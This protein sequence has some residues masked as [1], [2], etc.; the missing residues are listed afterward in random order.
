[1]KKWFV[2]LL[3]LV[4][5]AGCAAS[6]ETL[7]PTEETQKAQLANPWV[8]YE[9]LTEA[10]EAVGFPFS[11]DEQI[12]SF[13]A[14]SFRVMNGKLLEVGY[15]DADFRVTVRKQPGQ[16]QDLSGVYEPFSKETVYEAGGAEFTSRV[17]ADTEASLHLI[18][19]DGYS[20]SVYAP[21]GYPEDYKQGLLNAMLGQTP[22]WIRE[23][24]EAFCSS[25]WENG[26]TRESEIS[27]FFTSTWSSPEEIDLFAFLQ[28]CPLKE[29]LLDEHSEEAQA[30]IAAAGKNVFAVTPVWRY[31]KE[32][33]SSLLCKYTGITV[34]DLRSRENV[35]YLEEYDA[36]YNFT[37]DWG[38]G[39]F[40]CT[41]GEQSGN[42]ITLWGEG[43]G[44]AARTLTLREENG[45]YF[46][47]SFL[48]SGE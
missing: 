33:V 13:R 48:D 12:E 22:T 16:W 45:E 44:G 17:F 43:T 26:T 18:S 42:L 15:R 46:L 20:W 7:Q 31:P 32:A 19:V 40:T 23:A 28:Y 11:L 47:V 3:A 10:E 38:P 14:E 6:E 8:S 37:S 27:C 2:C 41:G 4:M 30:V 29:Q 35:L 34:E 24:N 5:L 39:R 9:T 21:D 1:M 36:F 25:V